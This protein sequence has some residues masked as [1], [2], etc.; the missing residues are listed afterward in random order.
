MDKQYVY[1]GPPSS[2]TLPG[3]REVALHPGQAVLLPEENPWVRTN[4]AMGHLTPA[5]EQDKPAARK[6]KED[7]ADAS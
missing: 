7:T 5:P 2:V 1:G 4:L 6:R 3:G